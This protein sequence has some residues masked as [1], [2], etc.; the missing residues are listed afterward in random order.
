MSA[1]RYYQVFTYIREPSLWAWLTGKI[2]VTGVQCLHVTWQV[3]ACNIDLTGDWTQDI[4]VCQTI[5]KNTTEET[6]CDEYN[7]A[8]NIE[9]LFSWR[10]GLELHLYLYTDKNYTETL[11]LP[12]SL[13]P[14]LHKMLTTNSDFL[15]AYF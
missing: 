9:N 15:Y 13:T 2:H 6:F 7:H 4:N 5:F 12:M 8:N 3:C 11:S 1:W 10:T 14:R